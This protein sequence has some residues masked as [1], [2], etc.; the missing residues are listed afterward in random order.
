MS[1]RDRD[2]A[3]F[4]DDERRRLWGGGSR[5]SSTLDFRWPERSPVPLAEQ[6]AGRAPSLRVL[7]WGTV[8]VAAIGVIALAYAA[9]VRVDSPRPPV[10][11]RVY[12]DGPTRVGPGGDRVACTLEALNTRVGAWVCIGWAI[13]Q[14]GQV[15]LQAFD[16][17]GPCG[18]RHA[19]QATGR[20][21][22]DGVAAPNPDSLPN[23]SGGPSPTV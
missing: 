13:L 16:P 20:W 8:A 21:M 14:P 3:R 10:A 7:V 2:W 5:S 15:A 1:W 6:R 11:P 23:P 22:C 12:A 18:L 19:D 4:T 17:G 9:R